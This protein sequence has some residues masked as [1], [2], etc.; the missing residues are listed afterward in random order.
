VVRFPVL[1]QLEVKGYQLYPGSPPGAGL[2]LA[3]AKGPWLLLGVNGLGK[4]TLLLIMRYLLSGPFWVVGAGPAGTIRNDVISADRRI[5][6][7]RASFG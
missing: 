5:F 7:V 2:D 1:E 4:S 6:A 3:L